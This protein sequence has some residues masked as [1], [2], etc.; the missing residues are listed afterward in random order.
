MVTCTAELAP[1]GNSIETGILIQ[2]TN[3]CHWMGGG[4]TPPTVSAVD[5]E[6]WSRFRVETVGSKN[7]QNN[8]LLK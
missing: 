1:R 6:Y 4:K 3:H 2:F 5:S 7:K 8:L